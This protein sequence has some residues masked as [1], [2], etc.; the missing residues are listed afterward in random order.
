MRDAL[1]T[2]DQVLAFCG[3]R[4][5]DEEVVTLLGVVDRRLLLETSR[6]VFAGDCRRRS[7]SSNGSIPSATICASSARN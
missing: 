1:S 2:L 7:T 5:T 3:E 4:S 6:A